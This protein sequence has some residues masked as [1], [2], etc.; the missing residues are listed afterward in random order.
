MNKIKKN[1]FSVYSY[2][3]M[4]LFLFLIISVFQTLNHFSN[5][6]DASYGV[7]AWWIFL[8]IISVFN[9]GYWFHSQSKLELNVTH[10]PKENMIF[11]KWQSVLSFGYVMGCALRSFYPK[12][13]VQRICL[14]ENLL[15]SVLAGR[16]IAT[17]AELCFAIQ[18][19]LM[20]REYSK[21]LNYKTGKYISQIMVILIFFAE[22]FS[23]SAVITTC[24]L[25]NAIEESLWGIT[26]FILG[27]GLLGVRRKVHESQ[28]IFFNFSI[29]IAFTYV[30][31]MAMVDVPMYIYRFIEDQKNGKIY[32]DFAEGMM[33]LW[34][35]RVV[36][37][38]LNDWTS[39]MPWMTLYFSVAVLISISLINA[40][41]LKQ[42]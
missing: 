25:G 11:R 15:S 42:K 13:D 33:D 22:L 41:R 19:A 9:I 1:I 39:E 28:K 32:L 21:E 29:L 20:L 31:F 14:N 40:P 6:T 18:L 37:F 3:S 5:D 7:L 36:T 24:Y 30:G 23:W 38:S 35:R 16:T 4:F 12:A 34:N 17:V 27:F 26:M 2:F 10:L 8:I